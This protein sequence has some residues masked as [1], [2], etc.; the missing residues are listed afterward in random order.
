MDSNRKFY[1]QDF[2]WLAVLGLLVQAF[3]AAR[4]PEPAYLDSYYYTTNGAR[5]AAGQGF[6][7]MV[8]WQYLDM[9]TG[10]PA[11]SHTY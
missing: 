8:L 10:L 1:W 4:V 5:L 11:P 3:W 9:P 6:T 7:E 2:V